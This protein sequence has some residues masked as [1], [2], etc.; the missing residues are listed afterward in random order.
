MLCIS[1]ADLVEIYKI[2]ALLLKFFNYL[3]LISLDIY[4]ILL[5]LPLNIN[6]C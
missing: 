4:I 5:I 6:I 3:P 1:F 2:S